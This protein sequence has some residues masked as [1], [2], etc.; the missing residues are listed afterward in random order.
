MIVEVW[1]CC[2]NA[3]ISKTLYDFD[4]HVLMI[5]PNILNFCRSRVQPERLQFS[6]SQQVQQ[7]YRCIARRY[8]GERFSI[9]F[10]GKD[11][12]KDRLLAFSTLFPLG[13]NTVYVRL[14]SKQAVL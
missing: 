4:I 9:L 13:K 1:L 14:E 2:L 7:L 8:P 11:V 6:V 10:D 5:R 12:Y 3:C